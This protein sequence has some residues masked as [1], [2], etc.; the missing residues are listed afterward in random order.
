LHQERILIESETTTTMSK[1]RPPKHKEEYV[2]PDKIDEFPEE[3]LKAGGG[4]L[5]P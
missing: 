3:I 4:I 2:H 5:H 1:A